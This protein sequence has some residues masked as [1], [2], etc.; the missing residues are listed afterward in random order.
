[1]TIDD[2]KAWL[3][4][5]QRRVE[6]K[7]DHLATD[8]GDIKIRQARMCV[9]IEVVKIDIERSRDA[10]KWAFRVVAGAVLVAVT[11]FAIAGGLMP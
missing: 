5:S 8:V 7:V 6:A 2:W 10:R 9:D 3:Q 11:G 4:E 1:M